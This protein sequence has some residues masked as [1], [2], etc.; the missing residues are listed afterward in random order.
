MRK[1]NAIRYTK[2]MGASYKNDYYKRKPSD[3]KGYK[4]KVGDSC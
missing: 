4:Y 1:K 3:S 2:R